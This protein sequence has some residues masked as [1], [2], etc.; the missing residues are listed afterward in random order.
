M[1]SGFNSR[2]EELFTM[3]GFP[4]KRWNLFFY[5]KKKEEKY[6]VETNKYEK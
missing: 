1:S 5:H 2:W 6:K 4:A 3:F